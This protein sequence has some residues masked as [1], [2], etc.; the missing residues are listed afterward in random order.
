MNIQIENGKVVEVVIG[1]E[2]FYLKDVSVNDISELQKHV[3]YFEKHM[4]GE[5][6]GHP[7]TESELKEFIE[8]STEKQRGM[9]EFLSK[10]PNGVDSLVLIK[11]L[12]LN[13]SQA[14][15]GMRAGFTKRTQ[16]DFG[17]KEEIV[18]SEWIKEKWM[19]EY[20]IKEE[21]FKFIKEYFESNKS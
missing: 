15:A 10:H 17:N 21:Y 8:D 9:L 6:E 5:E 3:S 12:G 18:E 11:E 2:K 14:I 1:G 19:N 20:W 13:T 7:W 16:R 4:Q